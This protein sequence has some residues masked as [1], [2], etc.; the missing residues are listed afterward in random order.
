MSASLRPPTKSSIK[1]KQIVTGAMRAVAT[2]YRDANRQAA[3]SLIARRAR[4]YA[5]NRG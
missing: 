4:A 1:G 3:A 2:L 5:S